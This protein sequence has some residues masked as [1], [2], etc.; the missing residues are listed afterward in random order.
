VEVFRS[1]VSVFP[2]KGS[3][4]TVLFSLSSA[5]RISKVY[6]FANACRRLKLALLD[7]FI[8]IFHPLD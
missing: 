2:T 1:S 6:T 3:T 7:L 5:K 4:L 8:N